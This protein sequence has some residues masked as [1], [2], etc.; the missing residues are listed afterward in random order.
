[1]DV[2]LNVHFQP[3][4]STCVVLI[5]HAHWAS[6]CNTLFFFLVF[7]FFVLVLLVRLVSAA[8]VF[9]AVA[10]AVSVVAALAVGFVG[11]HTSL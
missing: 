4:V 8:A 9:V 10:S 7:L 1:M 11:V 5:L 6:I 3:V 2:W